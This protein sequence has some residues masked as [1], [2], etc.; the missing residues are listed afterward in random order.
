MMTNFSFRNS[1]LC[2]VIH[3]GVKPEF[4]M[5]NQHILAN[6]TL[7]YKMSGKEK[8]LV[9]EQLDIDENNIK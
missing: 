1:G 5:R 7:S 8:V 3:I 6:I 4:L 2:L 9:S